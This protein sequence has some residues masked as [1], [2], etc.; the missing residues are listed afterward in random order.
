MAAIPHV[1]GEKN[2]CWPDHVYQGCATMQNTPG[3]SGQLT[4]H[5]LSLDLG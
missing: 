2:K 4:I 1:E 5:N 3:P